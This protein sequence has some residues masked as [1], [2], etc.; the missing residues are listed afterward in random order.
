MEGQTFFTCKTSPASVFAS[1]IPLVDGLRLR[2]HRPHD[3]VLSG[4]H[5]RIHLVSVQ[6]ERCPDIRVAQKPLHR[7]YVRSLVN[8]P[9]R[10]SM[11]EVVETEPLPLLELD[12]GCNG[13]RTK[14]VPSQNA[15]RPRCFP[16]AP[17]A[18]KHP[19]ARPS[20]NCLGACSFRIPEREET[21]YRLWPSA[22][23]R[24]LV[25]VLRKDD[26]P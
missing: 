10:Q 3:R 18:G 1:P 16:L 26:R 4:Q 20:V 23:F 15:A 6:A 25:R 19:I 8:Q 22:R 9:T 12:P 13:R 14:M 7:L 24:R 17:C 11:P 5:R 21:C 2:L